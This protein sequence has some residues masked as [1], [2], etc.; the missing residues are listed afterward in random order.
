MDT[1]RHGDAELILPLP[2]P[3]SRRKGEKYRRRHRRLRPLAGGVG[4]RAA[5]FPP[6]APQLLFSDLLLSYAFF[7]TVNATHRSSSSRLE[8]RAEFPLTAPATLRKNP[9]RLRASRRNREG[10][11]PAGSALSDIR[12]ISSPSSTNGSAA[13]GSSKT[14]GK[15]SAAPALS[16]ISTSDLTSPTTIDSEGRMNSCPSSCRPAPIAE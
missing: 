11:H 3:R 8:I 15:S 5:T 6:L 9:A 10:A 7:Q 1:E 2:L 4:P 12:N 14:S 13:N 16:P